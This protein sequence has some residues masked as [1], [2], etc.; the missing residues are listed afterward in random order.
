MKKI[1]LGSVRLLVGVI[2][3]ALAVAV[4]AGLW[5]FLQLRSSRPLLAGEAQVRGLSESVAIERDNLGVPTIRGAG[6]VDV[7]RALGWVHAQE[8][9]FQM[10]L[11]R[12]RAAGE[13]R[14]VGVAPQR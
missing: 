7:A 8:R 1:Y 4:V 3:V 6:R 9:F 12:R 11:L 2:S 13:G 14:R 10:D 5:F